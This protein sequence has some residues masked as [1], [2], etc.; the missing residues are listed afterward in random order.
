MPPKG[1][2]LSRMKTLASKANTLLKETK[3]VSKSLDRFGHPKAAGYARMAGYG[4][5]KKAKAGAKKRG[6]RK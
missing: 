4:K 6:K 1:S 2:L 5:K 3:I